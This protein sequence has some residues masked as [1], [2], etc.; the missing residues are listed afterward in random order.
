[1]VSLGKLRRLWYHSV[2]L[3]EQIARFISCEP[4]SLYRSM[5]EFLKSRGYSC[6]NDLRCPFCGSAFSTPLALRLH[7]LNAHYDE[8]LQLVDEYYLYR[9]EK[10]RASR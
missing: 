2:Y 7:I 10:K 8:L 4:H 5:V 6:R 9:D 3:P 1:M